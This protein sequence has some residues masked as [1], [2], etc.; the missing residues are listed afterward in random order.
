MAFWRIYKGGSGDRNNNLFAIN[1]PQRIWEPG[2]NWVPREQKKNGSNLV[3]NKGESLSTFQAVEYER[4]V[5][6]ML[7][8]LPNAMLGATSV[9]STVCWINENS[10]I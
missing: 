6:L 2:L 3:S 4:A 5:S 1:T 7:R 9:L 10:A 8:Y